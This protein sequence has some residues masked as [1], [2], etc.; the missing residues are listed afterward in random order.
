MPSNRVVS[1]VVSLQTA[2]IW[3]AVWSIFLLS[4]GDLLK[5]AWPGSE[6]Y[7]PWAGVGRDLMVLYLDLN[8]HRLRLWPAVRARFS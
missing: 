1:Y 5:W 8:A 2:C 4:L 3:Y 6:S 7:V